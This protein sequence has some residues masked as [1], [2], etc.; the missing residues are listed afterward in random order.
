MT[1]EQISK[2]N[3]PNTVSVPNLY[4]ISIP[5]SFSKVFF[6][7]SKSYK[8]PKSSIE[9]IRPMNC[10]TVSLSVLLMVQKRILFVL[11]AQ[12]ILVLLLS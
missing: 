7:Q 9:N 5:S 4:F 11:F 8:F 10:W 12:F 3:I 1:I 6:Q 2:T